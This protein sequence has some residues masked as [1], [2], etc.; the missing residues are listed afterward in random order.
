MVKPR[1]RLLPFLA[2]SLLVVAGWFVFSAVN[3]SGDIRTVDGKPA[4]SPPLVSNAPVDRDAPREDLIKVMADVQNINQ[5]MNE[6]QETINA[7]RQQN[8]E[9]KNLIA[10][11]KSEPK[12]TQSPPSMSQFPTPDSL[13]R[14]PNEGDGLITPPAALADRSVPSTIGDSLPPVIRDLQNNFVG[15]STNAQR[16]PASAADANGIVWLAPMDAGIDVDARGRRIANPQAAETSGT[17]VNLLASNVV[18]QVNPTVARVERDLTGN[19]RTNIDP[20]FTI[21][22]GSV[23]A[24]SRS[25]T[26]LVGKI[27]VQGQLTDPWRF[28]VSTGANIIMPNNHTL[29]GLERTIVEGT[30]IGDLN[31]SCVTGRIDVATF[32]FRDGRIVTQR[33]KNQ[34]EGLGYITDRNGNPCIP[35]TLIT[36]AP[37]AIT[38]LSALGALEGLANAYAA[39]ETTNVLNSAGGVTSSVT[40]DPLRAA[41]FSALSGGASEVKKWFVDRMGQFFDVIYVPANQRVDI[42]ISEAIHLDYNQEGRMVRYEK[43]SENGYMD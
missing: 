28:R 35:G 31:L 7:L 3:K 13:A 32:I 37:Q 23:I 11:L 19:Q 18:N 4:G 1:N 17:G 9:Q 25:V 5:T 10:K 21:P 14:Q 24:D 43:A 22:H 34:N 16:A 42:L 27:P 30:A 33:S 26:A 41:G 15:G 6:L 8:T 29:P 36:N 40:G 39:A 38:Q 12:P 2:V 20:R